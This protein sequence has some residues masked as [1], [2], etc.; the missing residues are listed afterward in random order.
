MA[1]RTGPWSGCT[2]CKHPSRPQID[3][4]LASGVGSKFVAQRFRVSRHAVYRHARSHLT[5]E[6][7]AAIATKLLQREGDI[8]KVLLEEG[9]SIVD[10]LRPLRGALYHLFLSATESGDWKAATSIS[11]RIHESFQLSAKLTGELLPHATTN[12]TNIVLSPDYQRLRSEL[13][14]ALVRH[15]DAHRDVVAIFQRVGNEAATMIEHD[16][17]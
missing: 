7:R 13:L 1:A 6:V 17:A 16:A 9:A 8:R 5:P 14:R 2:I 15:P 4:A 3:L 10:G 11:A 12:I